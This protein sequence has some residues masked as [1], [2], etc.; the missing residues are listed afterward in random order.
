VIT[1]WTDTEP[2]RIGTADE[3]SIV[4]LRADGSPGRPT[5]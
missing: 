3:L 5:T 1:T 4:P 2:D